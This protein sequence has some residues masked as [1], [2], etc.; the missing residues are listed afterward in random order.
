LKLDQEML[1]FILKFL[2]LDVDFGI[3]WA[4][5]VL[6]F[7]L[8]LPEVKLQMLR[9][10][11]GSSLLILR[12]RQVLQQLLITHF[13]L[14]NLHDLRLH[15]RHLLLRC[16]Q[17]SLLCLRTLHTII[18]ANLLLSSRFSRRTYTSTFAIMKLQSQN[19]LLRFQLNHVFFQLLYLIKL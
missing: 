16:L 6:Q 10:L 5:G 19:L 17:R 4:I 7:L 11:L 2:E 9:L 3:F 15:R 1:F 18:E 8:Q 14:L 12:H 13:Q